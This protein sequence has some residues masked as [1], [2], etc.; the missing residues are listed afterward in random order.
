[1]PAL[2]ATRTKYNSGR[3]VQ[4]FYGLNAG[5]SLIFGKLGLLGSIVVSQITKINAL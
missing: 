5:K 2:S 1:M 3:N 4:L